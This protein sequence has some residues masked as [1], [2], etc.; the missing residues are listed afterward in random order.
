MALTFQTLSRILAQNVLLSRTTLFS[1]L[2]LMSGTTIHSQQP[3]VPSQLSDPLSP[4]DNQNRM[5]YLENFGSPEQSLYRPSSRILVTLWT[6][7]TA[8]QWRDSCIQET[9]A[10]AKN[11]TLQHDVVNKRKEITRH[12]GDS[13][14]GLLSGRRQLVHLQMTPDYSE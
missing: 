5:H 10:R 3:L 6:E 1:N 4:K 8:K 14:T 12:T 7:E 11:V 13:R 2:A 9:Q